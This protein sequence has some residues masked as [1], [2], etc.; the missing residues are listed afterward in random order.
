MKQEKICRP[1]VG[2]AVIYPSSATLASLLFVAV[3]AAAQTAEDTGSGEQKML[4]E[5]VV[6]AQ[7]RET[8]LQTTP[9]AVSAVTSETLDNLGVSHIED[10]ARFVPGLTVQQT[11]IQGA[12]APAIRGIGSFSLVPSASFPVAYYYDGQF[13]D[14]PYGVHNRLFDVA[15]VEVLR[16]PQGV[17]F[18]RN[19]TAGAVRIEHNLPD[20]QFAALFRAS[21]G[22]FESRE[23]QASIRGPVSDT[24]S[25][26]IAGTY[27]ESDGYAKNLTTGKDIYGYDVNGVRGAAVFEPSEDLRLILRGSHASEK[28]TMGFKQI[29]TFPSHDAAIYHHPVLGPDEVAN[30]FPSFID[31]ETDAASAELQYSFSGFD[32]FGMVGWNQFSHHSN[33]DTDGGDQVRVLRPV[34]IFNITFDEYQAESTEWRIASTGW[35]R[36]TLDAGVY[37]IHEEHDE[38]GSDLQFI[39]AAG[40][41]T[42]GSHTNRGSNET[43][44]YAVFAHLKYAFTPSLSVRAGVRY[45]FEEKH[46]VSEVLNYV[47]NAIIRLDA[48]DDWSAVTPL[49]GLDYAFGDDVFGYATISRGFKSG[50]FGN[51]LTGV[52]VPVDQESVTSYEIGLKSDLFDGRVRFNNAVF[53]TDYKDLQVTQNLPNGG[54]ITNNAASATIYGLESEITWLATRH[55]SMYAS[56]AYLN[57]EFDDYQYSPTANLGGERLDRAPDWKASLVAEYRWDTALGGFSAQTAYSFED[58]IYFQSIPNPQRDQFYERPSTSLVD[59]RLQWQSAEEHWSVALFGSNLTDERYFGAVNRLGGGTSAVAVINQPRAYRVEVSYRY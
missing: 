13:Q 10:L 29:I 28:S 51:D 6:T 31:H 27:A 55:L 24:V 21:A 38:A 36:L 46:Y 9:A 5:I 44:A 12:S 8:A 2:A 35:D 43:D 16:G 7:R 20:D 25:L 37:Y 18:G 23:L 45:S 3:G 30:N 41:R 22:S 17:L 52:P 50:A 56:L 34:S 26:G 53:Y 48:T 47:N 32:L 19:A 11:T 42:S 40:V 15:R 39:N 14:R 33:S 54:A 1:R 57:A 58:A 49:V 59:A 4:E